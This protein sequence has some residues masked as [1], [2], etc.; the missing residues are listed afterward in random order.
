MRFSVIISFLLL[1]SVKVLAG[2]IEFFHGTWE[3]ALVKAM[4]EEKL[5]FVDAYTTWC[6]P[7]KRMA[8][9][10]FT[11]DKVGEFYNANF[12]C[13]KIDMEK[14]DGI[15]FQRN[16]PV[17]AYP[18]LYY[19]DGKGKAVHKVKGGRQVEDFLTLG[20]GVL[21]KVDYSADYAAAYDKGD[22]DP[23]L[24]YNYVRALNKAGKPSLKIANAYIKEQKDLTTPDNLKFILE[25]TTEADSRIFDLLIQNRSAIEAIESK[26]IVNKKI[27]NAC[28]VT[29]KKAIEFEYE[30][31]H[32]E[33]KD[34]MKLHY[35]KKAQEFAYKQDLNFYKNFRNSGKYLKVCNEYV[36]KVVKKDA[37][38]LNS[39]AKEVE[40][41]FSS[42]NKAMNFA[43]KL[44]KKAA[45]QGKAHNYYLTYA[46][47]LNKN[48][49]KKQ[50]LMNANKS[51]EMARGNFAAEQSAQNLIRLIKEG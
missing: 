26:E 47:I 51:L 48:G 17:S 18:T 5:I 24:V 21:G 20:R 10:V 33:A 13:M 41:H 45:E 50:A 38:Q 49:K 11:N 8:K 16:Y 9:T 22:R 35:P 44:A 23:E 27:L 34:K 19:I 6:G 3:E 39:L 4:D 14:A 46:Q 43:E 31:L 28:K 40:N 12:I 42:N 15:T 25:A 7:C 37:V 32:I 36:K 1:T 30:E 2:G 29:A